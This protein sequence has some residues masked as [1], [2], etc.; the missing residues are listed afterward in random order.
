M[1]RKI[2]CNLR[3]EKKVIEDENEAIDNGNE[4]QTIL[5]K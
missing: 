3:G 5:I 4:K 1:Q 2:I